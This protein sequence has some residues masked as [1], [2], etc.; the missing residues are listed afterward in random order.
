[1]VEITILTVLA[2]VREPASF[3]DV[4]K[5]QGHMPDL[6]VCNSNFLVYIPFEN[7]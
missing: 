2:K 6:F 4:H 7:E 1:V 3:A 5:L